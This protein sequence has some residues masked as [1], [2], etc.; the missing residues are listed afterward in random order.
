V[1]FVAGLLHQDVSD[2]WD[3]YSSLLPI[4]FASLKAQ[5]G[6][7]PLPLS[8]FYFKTILLRLQATTNH[9]EVSALLLWE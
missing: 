6:M 5:N 4:P 7:K 8:F 9:V 3:I 1:P 2:N